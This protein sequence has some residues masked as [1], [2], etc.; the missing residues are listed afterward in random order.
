MLNGQLTL[1]DATDVEALCRTV[2]R[3][4][5]RNIEAAFAIAGRHYSWHQEQDLLAYYIE[6]SWRLSETYKPGNGTFASW[7]QRKL[8]FHVTVDWLRLELKRTRWTF[9]NTSYEREPPHILSLDT[10]DS[11]LDTALNR[12]TMD[13]QDAGLSDLVRNLRPRVSPTTRTPP[14]MGQPPARHAA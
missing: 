10:P 13:S 9:A 3:Q 14:H 7:L 2:L 4:R 1:H 8:S 11:G 6:E 5:R 12:G